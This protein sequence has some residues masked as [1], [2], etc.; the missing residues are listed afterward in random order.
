MPGK[1]PHSARLRAAAMPSRLRAVVLDRAGSPVSG[2]AVAFTAPAA[3]AS[4]M[5]AGTGGPAV[6]VT[7]NASGVALAPAFTANAA[8]GR[9]AVSAAAGGVPSPASFDLENAGWYVSSTGR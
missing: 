4:G 5:F 8:G 6:T 9:F 1:A 7:T 2:V 3:G